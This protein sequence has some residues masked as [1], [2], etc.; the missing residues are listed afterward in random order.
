MRPYW[1]DYYHDF[2]VAN[3]ASLEVARRVGDGEFE[4]IVVKDV[5]GKFAKSYIDEPWVC[6]DNRLY[7]YLTYAEKALYDRMI[8][9]E[10]ERHASRER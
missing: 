1:S 6:W 9:E 10:L 4:S 7:R 2:C 3:Q 5:I 8:C